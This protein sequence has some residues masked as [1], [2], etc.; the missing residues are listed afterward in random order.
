MGVR[1]RPRKLKQ[2]VVIQDDPPETQQEVSPADVELADFL[3]GLGPAG[4][5]E[6]KLSRIER[7]G[8]QLFLTSG[9]PSQFSELYVQVT[10]GAGDY[11]VRAYKD[12][13]WQGSKN[14]S[15]G[16]APGGSVT[17]A[18]GSH[19]SELERAKLDLETQRLRLQEQQQKMDTDR[20]ELERA[21]REN[22]QRNHELMIE[23]LKGRGAESSSIGD[24]VGAVK[25]MHDMTLSS[26][27]TRSND[28]GESNPGN[29]RA[30]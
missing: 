28:S 7:T 29:D 22:D 24:L 6:V 26:T 18:N 20:L 10:F 12:G 17:S 19:E 30:C 14:F 2:V 11:M 13:K 5:T 8:K 3:D 16:S 21:R 9:S 15:V 25:N 23:V 4:I 27:S 1:G